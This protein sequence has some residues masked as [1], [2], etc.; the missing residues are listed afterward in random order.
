[1]SYEIALLVG[2]VLFGGYFAFSGLNH[3][4]NS[5]QLSGWVESKGFPA[6]DLLVYLSGLMLLA[7]GLGIAAGAFPVASIL[8]VGIF[9]AA[10][11]PTF[12]DFWKFEG[13]EKQNHM[14]NF[15]KNVALIGA[16]LMALSLDW[17]VYA[18]GMSLG[19]L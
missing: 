3:F 2:R 11:T 5:D 17:S 9:L 8:L 4:M 14:V 15:M 10:V 18:A 12:H 6:P 16:L 19:L 1:M 13:E 7:G